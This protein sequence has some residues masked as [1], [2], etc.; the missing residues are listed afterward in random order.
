MEYRELEM[1]IFDLPP[2]YT[3]AHCIS[4]D[5]VMGAGIA[6]E[7]ASRYSNLRYTL[8]SMSLGICEVVGY[9]ESLN[10]QKV[11]NLVT[12]RYSDD[13]PRRGVFN[14]T[15]VNM[16]DICLEHDIKYLGVPRLGSGL[17]KL[18]WNK[19]RE[20]IKEVFE[21]TDVEIVVCIK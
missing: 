9:Y 8:Q 5:A 4:S 7:F 11:L 10:S 14:Q 1:D 3:L 18:S 20:W 2:H 17:D 12:K 19:S 13:K 16:K 15:I 21:D 6:V